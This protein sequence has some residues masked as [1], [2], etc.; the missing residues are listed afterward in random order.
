MHNGLINIFMF[1]L[2]LDKIV[3]LL[4]SKSEAAVTNLLQ[5]IKPTPSNVQSKSQNSVKKLA[6]DSIIRT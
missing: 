5:N 4:S 3:D 2:G 6:L 1:D